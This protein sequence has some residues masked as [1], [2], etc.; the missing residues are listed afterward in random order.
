MR[1]LADWFKSTEFATY[2]GILLAVG[3]IGALAAAAPLVALMSGIG[4]RASMTAVGVVSIA[5]AVLAY[6]VI[7]NKPGEVGGATPAQ[8]EGRLNPKPL[9]RIRSA[10][11]FP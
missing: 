6:L 3:N 4:W 8:I 5:V 1:F 11:P 7:R 9:Q 2:S 10:R